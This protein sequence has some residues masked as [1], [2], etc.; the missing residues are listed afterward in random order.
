MRIEH[1][2][3]PFFGIHLSQILVRQP[4]EGRCECFFLPRDLQRVIVSHSLPP[5]GDRVVN[6][7]G[8][9]PIR[10]EDQSQRWKGGHVRGIVEAEIANRPIQR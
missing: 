6:R 5:A 9:E 7:H 10:A 2:H 3:H 8:D 4:R 1:E